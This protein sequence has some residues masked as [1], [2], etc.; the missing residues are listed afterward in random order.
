MFFRLTSDEH[1]ADGE[2]LL[3]VGVW[4]HVSKA[5]AGQR[6]ER[7]VQRGHVFI[8]DGRPRAV[9]SRVAS[10]PEGHLEIVEPA[11]LM[12]QVRFL[13]VSNGIPDAGQPMGDQSK[14]T[15]EQHENRRA[16]FRVTVQLPGNTNQSEEP[17]RLQQAN[18]SGRLEKEEGVH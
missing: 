16:V 8:L 15:H 2:D 10:L 11:D 14:Y 17:R 3:R 7:E 4:R 12:L 1:D 5:H 9:L 6:A 18:Q 13:H